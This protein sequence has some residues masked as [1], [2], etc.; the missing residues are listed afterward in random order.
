MRRSS[1]ALVRGRA[2][3]GLEL[4]GEVVLDNLVLGL[5]GAA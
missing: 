1:L 3:M 5:P 4:S 2:E